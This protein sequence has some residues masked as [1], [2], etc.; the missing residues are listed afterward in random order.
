MYFITLKTQMKLILSR[1]ILTISHQ[2]QYNI[3]GDVMYGIDLNKEI[4]YRLASL[5]FFDEKEHHVNR[6]CKDDVLLLVFDGVL[7]FSEDGVLYELH[8][9][10]YHIQKHNSIQKGPLPSDSP[11][12]FYVHFHADWTENSI[13]PKKGFFDYVRLKLKFE[14]LN[15]L[16]HNH[17]PYIIQAS[18]FYEILTSLCTFAVVDTIANKIARYINQ[19]YRNE[20][21]IDILCKE[22]SFSKNH[23]INTF[24]KEFGQ[25]PISYLN[26]TRISKAEELLIATSNSIENIAYD[27]GYRNYSHFYRQFIHKNTISPEEFRK[28]K[29]LGE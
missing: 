23:I 24:K 2:C 9:G 21:T 17:F 25:T 4:K 11:K 10:Q 29:R 12:Y 28:R 27:C 20:I 3:F 22:F 1:I 7:R 8:P 6:L 18:K 15:Y 14:E 26:T 13:L 5:R 19:N 16:C